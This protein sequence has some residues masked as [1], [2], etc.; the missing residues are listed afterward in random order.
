MNN[1][2]I[3]I[4]KTMN[5]TRVGSNINDLITATATTLCTSRANIQATFASTASAT[6][7]RRPTPDSIAMLSTLT[8][9][10]ENNKE[11]KESLLIVPFLISS[12]CIL[13]L[14]IVFYAG[15]FSKYVYRKHNA[16]FAGKRLSRSSDKCQSSVKLDPP[17]V[18]GWGAYR[19]QQADLE[20]SCEQLH[21]HLFTT[22]NTNNTTTTMT[23]SSN[24]IINNNN[25]NESSSKKQRAKVLDM[26]HIYV[27]YF[28][29]LWAFT[30]IGPFS[31]LLWKKAIILLKLRVFL[32]EKVKIF[33]KKSVD[34]D[35]LV[36][37]L[38]LEQS[39]VIHYVG[40]GAV[41]IIKKDEQFS[42]IACFFFPGN[43]PVVTLIF[44][45]ST[46]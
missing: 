12:S 30:F 26:D 25:D 29:L 6:V 28:Q 24:E 9:I 33:K 20:R 32:V 43:T 17:S 14:T 38:V 36:G 19:R 45:C 2:S 27:N 13:A 7:W 44:C 46:L 16:D 42:T 39:Q 41:N 22:T 8:Q 11:W 5:I 15:A 1:T 18:R 10:I 3:N 31:Y 37:K 34:L 35:K 4:I 40:R 21:P 23:T